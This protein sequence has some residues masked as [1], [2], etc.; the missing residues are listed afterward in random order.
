MKI[1]AMVIGFAT[2]QNL[3]FGFVIV[4]LLF[5]AAGMYVHEAAEL[6]WCHFDS[7]MRRL[8]RLYKGFFRQVVLFLVAWLSWDRWP[9]SRPA[10]P[11][12][13]IAAVREQ[14][15]RAP[16]RG[17]V[18]N[19]PQASYSPSSK[20]WAIFVAN[21]CAELLDEKW[22]HFTDK[23]PMNSFIA[24]AMPAAMLRIYNPSSTNFDTQCN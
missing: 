3:S 15:L 13:P 22:S 5:L 17:D 2:G 14:Q 23:L 12:R 18:S 8:I 20:K 24:E 1:P 7:A 19:M 6:R 16:R 10:G 4:A 11:T 21:A 9:A